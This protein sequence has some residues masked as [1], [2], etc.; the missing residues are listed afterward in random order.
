M[1]RIGFIGTGHISVPMARALVRDGHEVWTS[2][3][4]AVLSAELS[5]SHG[6]RVASN[7][8]VVDAVEIVFLCLRPNVAHEVIDALSFRTEHHIVSVIA[9]LT[10]AD[11][12]RL[13]APAT[14]LT[15]TIPIGF[16]EKG[17][18]PLPAYPDASVLGPLFGDRNP[19]IPVSSEHAMLAHFGVTAMLPGLLALMDT[20]AKWLAERTGDHDGAERYTAQ[21]IQGFLTDMTVEEGALERAYSALATDGTLSLQMVDA[22]RDAGAMDTLR[23]TMDAIAKRVGA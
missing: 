22:L 10:E 17:G 23:Q 8:Q 7:Q 4:N 9:G 6:V 2:E 5:A 1:S 15:M 11:L 3:R 16:M 12:R 13:C 14:G 18:C 19:V 21:L 20:G